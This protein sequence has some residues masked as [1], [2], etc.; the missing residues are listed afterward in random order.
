MSM[1]PAREFYDEYH[2]HKVPHLEAVLDS[3]RKQNAGTERP[4]IWLSGDSSLDN[5][6]WLEGDS[7]R[8]ALNGYESVLVPPSSR[9]DV[10]YHLNALVKGRASVINCAIE[11]SCVGQ[12]SGGKLLP[13]DEFLRDN[14]RSEDV[15]VV[16]VGGNDIALAPSRRTIWNMLMMMYLNSIK[17]LGKGPRWSWGMPYFVRMF[18]DD[19]RAYIE[20]LVSKT[21][22]ALVVVCMIYFPDERQTGSWADQVLGP[23]GYN[24]NPEKL[25]TVIRQVYEHGTQKIVVAGT[26]VVPLP[27]FEVLD[28]KDSSLYVDRVEPSDKGGRK[29]AE[30]IWSSIE[31][32]LQPGDRHDEL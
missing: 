27:L 11:E 1:I 13:Q 20:Q 19:V 6:Y 17:T 3:L 5:K 4:T 9:P 10:C 26:Q 14:L 7:S 29:V 25:Q 22:P 8:R 16:S 12:R 23:L 32:R 21:K 18:R 24:S 31:S 30:Q 15:V 28:G 2:G